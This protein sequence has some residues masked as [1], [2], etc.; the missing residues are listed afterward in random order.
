MGVEPIGWPLSWRVW[1]KRNAIWTVALCWATKINSNESAVKSG[2]LWRWHHAADLHTRACSSQPTIIPLYPHLLCR[3]TCPTR[4]F[5]WGERGL[6]GSGEPVAHI[7]VSR[8]VASTYLARK[9]THWL[10]HVTDWQNICC[11]PWIWA[12]PQQEID[13]EEHRSLPRL[14]AK[15][16]QNRS[17]GLWNPLLSKTCTRMIQ[18]P[19]FWSVLIPKKVVRQLKNPKACT[20][21]LL[22]DIQTPLSPR[23]PSEILVLESNRSRNQPATHRMKLS[24]R[25]KLAYK[26]LEDSVDFARSFMIFSVALF[27]RKEPTCEWLSFA[28]PRRSAGRKW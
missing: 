5:T 11:C 6:R 22:Y 21:D 26:V 7:L 3:I 10:K 18:K 15:S 1:C 23:F 12:L 9:V 17:G 2:E 8:S 19:L 24:T 14:L 16:L 27:T 28:P 20:F 25:T 13:Q 4:Y